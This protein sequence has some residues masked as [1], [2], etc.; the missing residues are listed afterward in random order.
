M[1]SIRNSENDNTKKNTDRN[2]RSVSEPSVNW[3]RIELKWRERWEQRKIFHSDPDS[4]RKKYFITVAYPYPNSPQHVGHGRTYTLA[5]V[6]ARYMRMKGYNVL[7]PMGFHYTGTPILAM[8][9][10]VASRDKD[11]WTTFS[12]I[13][14]VPYN[15]IASFV[16]PVKIARY[17]HN[18][19]KLGMREMGFSIDW[20]R[21]F[22]TV[23]KIYSKFISWQFRT[24][25]KKG[26]V[27]QGSHP[28]GWCPNDQNPVSQH[29]TMGDIE[30]AFNEFT[31]IKFRL[32]DGDIVP[33][34]TSRPETVYG[35]TNLWINPDAEYFKI[36]LNNKDE[37]WVVSSE[38]AAKLENLGHKLTIES[39]MKGKEMIGKLAQNP[40]T[41]TT[42][43]IY[44]GFF[45]E[46]EDGTGL[47]MS[48]PAHAPYDYQALEDLK[49]N[50]S[51]QAEFGI[52]LTGV[53]PIKIIDSGDGSR[54]D[55]VPAR[56]V[57]SK[58]NIKDQT[59]Q[60]L[61]EATNELYSSEFYKGTMLQNAG[62]YSGIPV[63]KAKELIK[64]EILK[65]GYG[66]KLFEFNNKPV[67]CR[68][69]T[70]CVVK[71]LNDQ[72]FL[73][74][75]NPQWKHL[76]H[77]CLDDMEILPSEIREEFNHV[78]DWL[79]ERACSR[80]SGL[81]TKLPWDEGWVIESLSDSVIYMA[82]YIL[83]KYVNNNSI[84]DADNLTDSMF[85]YVI[86]GKGDVDI[87]ASECGVP[88]ELLKELRMEFSYFYPVDSR[89][90]GR[91]LVS[92]HLSFFIFGH[93]AIFER[94]Y[95]PKQIVVNGS[96]MMEGK[97][98]SKSLRNIIPLR[99][100][101]KEH[102]ADAIRVALLGSAELL[103]DADFSFDSVKG[104]RS[105]LQDIY[106]TTMKS[107]KYS[108]SR[109]LRNEADTV[110][111]EDRWLLSRLQR[112]IADATI[113]MDNLRV[114]EA[115]QIVIYL[116]DQDLRWYT[117]RVNA[118]KRESSST[119]YALWAFLSTR[120]RMLAPIA[121]FISEEVWE[122]ITDS[123]SS[124]IFAGWP[125]VEEDNKDIL[126]EESE[127]LIMGLVLD[128][129]RIVRLTGINPR[130]ISF[131]VASRWK[132]RV[133]NKILANVILE[134][135]TNFGDIMKKLVRDPETTKAGSYSD[136][137]RKMLEDILSD[138]IETRDRRLQ[139]QEYNFDEKYSI[140]DARGL[141]S[142]ESGYDQAEIL[143]YSEDDK[144]LSKH[145][146]QSKARF[147]RPFKPA[148]YISDK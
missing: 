21:E 63:T 89:H 128:L 56:E 139:L 22:T 70:T 105:K 90:S 148:I 143:V 135:N 67:V 133:Y 71:L 64:G 69:G 146:P 131:Y 95:W 28:V 59:D 106:Y 35:V 140:E 134:S 141:L 142:L 48:V 80:K 121:P 45:V 129:H 83:A 101:I 53:V 132:L 50:A 26:L 17:F 60:R 124:I 16:D 39:H 25:Q 78:I 12:D 14:R 144:D 42:V 24:F 11:L 31:L 114:R 123:S 96:V 113:S 119:Y 108:M 30:P 23:D 3:N 79:R 118:K 84:P 43:P 109:P 7:F 72:W 125:E 2:E 136:L 88:A 107:S 103:Q 92:N 115:V 36:Y 138:P 19:I 15:E 75:G 27:I 85:D 32:P 18:E 122:K 55:V 120:I 54:A 116:L 137:V 117:K 49:N 98:M 20:R 62:K 52:N 57:I 8:S 41:S 100:A 86:L 87:V 127:Q 34:A 145:D 97:K 93:V 61:I 38:G 99:A 112:N 81:G 4:S 66:D 47:V 104:I 6:H 29:D 76:A 102:G 40:I 37:R 51:L 65:S 73:N 82:Y 147:A 46:P 68:C 126:A 94:E 91:D 111:L 44:P 9:R 5:D 1:A 13:Y 110:E 10:R 74:Y 33:T 130:R 77:E 58:F